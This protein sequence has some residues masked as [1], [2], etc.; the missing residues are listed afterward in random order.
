MVCFEIVVF[1]LCYC[2]MQALP[3]VVSRINPCGNKQIKSTGAQTI[4]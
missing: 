4:L 2:E 1:T 3:T